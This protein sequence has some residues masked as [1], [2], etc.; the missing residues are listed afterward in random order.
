MQLKTLNLIVKI[1]FYLILLAFLS[2]KQ[3][4][5]DS[6]L[7][8]YMKSLNSKN[9]KQLD[10][11]LLSSNL[12][13]TKKG[14]L[15]LKK[16]GKLSDLQKDKKALL[17]YQK[18]LTLFLKNNSS[19]YIAESY[20]NI[21]STY[22]FLSKKAEANKHLTKALEYNKNLNNPILDA[23]IY[24]SLAHIYYLYNDYD[25]AFEYIYKAIDIQKK[26]KDYQELSATYN[27]LAIIY[28][29][30]GNFDK[31]L[32]YNQKSLDLNKQIKNN[33][34]IAKSHNNL[35]SLFLDEK[36]TESAKKYF[37]KSIK[38]H[39]KTKS[40]ITTPYRNLSKVYIFENKL[41]SSLFF[42]K[43]AL[44][45]EKKS[46]NINNQLAIYSNLLK[47]SLKKKKLNDAYFYQA[48]KDSLTLIKSKLEN[49]E[50]LQ[51]LKNQHQLIIKEKEL[52][53]QKKIN[54][55][56]SI[57]FASILF[58]LFLTLLFLY[59]K[60]KN[61]K[62]QTKNEILSLEQKV[63][64]S[65][66]NPHFI[67][68]ALSAIQNSL[69]DNEP[70]KTAGYLSK[71]AKL[72]R[73][74]FDFIHQKSITLQEEIDALTNY[75]NT[76]RLR[77]NNSFDFKIN[78]ASNIDVNTIEI[79]PLL[80]QPFVEN[81]IEHGF[82]NQQQKGLINIHIYKET[83]NIIC[84]EI[85]DNGKGYTNTETNTEMHALDIF[86]KR[87]KLRGKNEGKWY[88]ITSSNKGTTIKFCLKND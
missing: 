48:K 11:I 10:S 5:E 70:I 57:L 64:R 12:S 45:I 17:Y 2:C 15:F 68:N 36:K 59:Q 86:K 18:A 38:L 8:L 28:K 34:A 56:N 20:W 61:K 13:D 29:N 42:L 53:Q 33:I 83:P 9:I 39:Q 52:N 3:S 40:L 71:F 55:K 31:A 21:G 7:D 81:A 35:G 23:N 82:K 69:L 51:L 14:I 75:L 67:F 25:K 32:K 66:M 30:I 49:E 73:Q 43:K 85:K 27:N 50:S 6:N 79:P 60:N 76:Q 65:Q 24:N 41:D 58:L 16:G 22:A 1:T 87:L 47:I 44:K 26:K 4:S 62:L 19:K 54:L 84:Y 37:L 72:I 74:N 46:G 63:L 88:S 78:I 80:L 77:Y